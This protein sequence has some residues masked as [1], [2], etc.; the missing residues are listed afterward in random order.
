MGIACITTA[1]KDQKRSIFNILLMEKN[2]KQ[3]A[4]IDCSKDELV[5]SF[6]VLTEELS[7][8]PKATRCFTNNLKGF[9]SLLAW[10]EKLSS[11]EGEVLFVLEATGVY[12]EA[13]SVFLIDHGKSVSIVLPNRASAFQKTLVCKTITDK[14]ASESL[15]IMGLQ[16]KLDLWQKPDEVFTLLRS[17]SRERNQL[18]KERTQTTNQLHAGQHS[19]FTSKATLQRAR[20]RLQLI[21]EQIKQIEQQIKEVVQS[22]SALKVKVTKLCTIK[23]IAWSTAVNIIAE[24]QGFALIKNRK[25]L[26]SY[27]GLDV[28]EHSSG[29]SVKKTAHLSR[30]G[31]KHLR[32]SMYMPSLTA[33]VYNASMKELY[34]RLLSKHGIKMKALAAVQ[35]KLLLLVYTL[36]KSGQDYNPLYENNK[37]SK[38]LEQPEKTALNELAL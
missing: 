37:T 19:V 22:S 16:R 29:T 25:Q 18:I 8:K 14:T 21:Q 34:L 24:T 3:C 10:A 9:S 20:Q 15:C 36:W 5:V 35:R 38:L 11:K 2:L 26:A 12:H 7:T 4:G 30:R 1:R 17:L 33:I 6:G 32:K 13:L 28:V 27:A 23:G 31:N